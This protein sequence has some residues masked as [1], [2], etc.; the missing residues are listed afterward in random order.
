MTTIVG[1]L[2]AIHARY[3]LAWFGL[4]GVSHWAR[5]YENGRMLAPSTGADERLLLL[6]ALFHDARRKNEGWD[7]GHGQRGADFA[8]SLR[9][10]GVDLAPRDFDLLYH[11]CA[12]HTD[13]LIDGD[14]TVQTCWDADRLDL[15]RAGIEPSP[16][17]L[18]TPAARAEPTIAWA[19]ERS[20]QRVVP[21]FVWDAWSV[22]G[23][24]APPGAVR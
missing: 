11:A 2:E 16:E 13:G 20:V 9:G 18:C 19:R 5:V 17:R 7:R 21:A 23:V 14:P 10:E 12:R 4:H 8:A 15:P 1:L 24:G 22:S 3:R 6:F